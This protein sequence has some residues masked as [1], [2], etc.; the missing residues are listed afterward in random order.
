ILS[1]GPDC[2]FDDPQEF[3]A[4]IQIDLLDS[5]GNFIRST[6]TNQNGEYTF[7]GLAPG[8]YQVREHQPQQYYDGGER[9]GSAGGA[10]HDV[11]NQYSVFTGIVITSDLDAVNYDFCEHIGANLSGWVYHD[12]SNEG[13]FNRPGEEGIGGVTVELL[14]N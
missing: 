10:K 12:R 6:T 3:L 4:G 5:Q 9:I 13:N 7:T 14:L 8:S 1:Q 11:G 2:D